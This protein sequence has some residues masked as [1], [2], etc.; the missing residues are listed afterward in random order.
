MTSEFSVVHLKIRHRSAGLTPP[1]ITMQKNQGIRV[2]LWS[3]HHSISRTSSLS[4]TGTD[5][6]ARLWKRFAKASVPGSY[7]QWRHP[8]TAVL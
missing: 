1:A 2:G 8:L 6:S 4:R 7:E 3:R 5:R